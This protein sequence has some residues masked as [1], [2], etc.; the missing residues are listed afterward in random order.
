MTT[1]A[2]ILAHVPRFLQPVLGPLLCLR[3]RRLERRTSRKLKPIIEERLTRIEDQTNSN[4]E[5]RLQMMLCYARDNV[6]QEL[7]VRDITGRLINANFGAMHQT[8]IAVTNTIL[9]MASSDA[10][11]DT[12]ATLRKEIIAVMG[13]HGSWT[14]QA[15]AQMV[16]TDSVIKETLR[17]HSFSSHIPRRVTAK[18]GVTTP[19][20]V[21]LPQDTMISILQRAPSLDATHFSNPTKYDPFRFSRRA[22]SERTFFPPSLV[23]ISDTNRSF[24]LGKHA[25]PGRFL[26]DFELKMI[27]AYLLLN[28][29]VRLAEEHSGVRPPP[30]CMFG[31]AFPPGNAKIEIKR[32]LNSWPS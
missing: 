16:S 27:V 14:R 9:N 5:D 3:I 1:C 4:P 18:D 19:D 8:S 26:V 20:G 7:N 6:P 29:D 12:I 24:G 2:G 28:Y 30:V 13:N 23:D 15:V 17:L 21:H 11:F 25:C 32:R 10:E 22:R 31:A